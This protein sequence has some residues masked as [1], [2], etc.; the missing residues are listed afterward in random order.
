MKKFKPTRKFIEHFVYKHWGE[1]YTLSSNH[2]GDWINVESPWRPKD[3][4]KCLGFNLSEKYVSD[5]YVSKTWSFIDFIKEFFELG[6]YSEAVEW[7]LV[8]AVT[9]GMNSEY[10]VDELDLI[11]EK[12]ILKKIEPAQNEILF[13]EIN[14]P[15]DTYEL[16]ISNPTENTKAAIDYLVKRRVDQKMIDDYGIRFCKYGR[17]GGRIIFKVN[18]EYGRFVWYQGRSIFGQ[19][20]KYLNPHGDF[21]SKLVYGLDKVK[22]GGRVIICEGVI[23]A[24]RISG[25]SIFGKSINYIQLTKIMN[26]KPGEFI[27]A[28]DRDIPGIGASYKTIDILEKNNIDFKIALFT[29]GMNDFGDLDDKDATKILSENVFPWNSKTK[30][31]I[32]MSLFLS[33]VDVSI[34]DVKTSFCEI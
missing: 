13:S 19:E 11:S 1:N 16:D 17:D 21:K 26:R 28:L 3:D 22:I 10:E 12:N 34:K 14:Y 18:D 2:R 25:Q 4:R 7:F 23:D 24:I 5:F 15:N 27:I 33:A 30:E 31:M 6:S 29:S 20:P 8:F 9:E 32:K